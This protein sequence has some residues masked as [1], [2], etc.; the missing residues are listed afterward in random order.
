MYRLLTITAL[1]ASILFCHLPAVA[2]TTELPLYLTD[3]GHVYVHADINDLNNIPMILDTAANVGVLSNDLKSRLELDSDSI[4][5]VPV[6]GA[7]GIQELEFAYIENTKVNHLDITDQPYVFRDLSD[8]KTEQGDIPGIL[9]HGFLSQHCVE[10]DFQNKQL[11]L[12]QEACTAEQI[13]GLRESEFYIEQNFVKL[14]TQF[15]GEPVDAILDTAATHSYL[16]KP[17]FSKLNMKTLEQETTQGLNEH[18]ISREKLPEVTFKLGQ[19]TLVDNEMFTSDMPVFTALGYQN[20]PAMLLGI[21]YFKSN[22]LIVD[23]HSN[24]I[25]Y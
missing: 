13:K 16:N 22:K 25:F 21:N 12:S 3:K 17:L 18:S 9:G 4:Q 14:K 15:N 11:H 19:N 7:G 6:Q 24:K 10:F 8:L 2:S 20:E 23:Y 1:K 5:K